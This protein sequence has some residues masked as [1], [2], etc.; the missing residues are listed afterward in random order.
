VLK[1]VARQ[2]FDDNLTQDRL[3]NTDLDKLAVAQ[4]HMSTDSAV[5]WNLLAPFRKDLGLAPLDS[6]P[7]D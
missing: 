5:A 1:T 3:V 4:R 6:H 7:T 2:V